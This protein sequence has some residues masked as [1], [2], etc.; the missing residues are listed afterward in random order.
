VTS[1]TVYDY[2]PGPLA[3]ERGM[4]CDLPAEWSVL[5]SCPCGHS[6]PSL[7]CDDHMRPIRRGD[8]DAFCRDCAAA[9]HRCPL[10][11]TAVEYL[12]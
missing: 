2:P 11:V 7:Q 3:P 12:P 9:G 10:E 1:C 5:S 8:V 6:G 4:Q